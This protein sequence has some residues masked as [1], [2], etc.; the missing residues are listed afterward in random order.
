L[1]RSSQNQK[2]VWSL[3]WLEKLAAESGRISGVSL[4]IARCIPAVGA[5][6]LSTIKI[7]A[8]YVLNVVIDKSCF[9]HHKAH[10]RVRLMMEYHLQ[11]NSFNVL[12]TTGNAGNFHGSTKSGWSVVPTRFPLLSYSGSEWIVS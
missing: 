11:P 12:T 3:L 6:Q 5:V 9:D 1:E 4:V 7:L 10:L 8:Q 2:L